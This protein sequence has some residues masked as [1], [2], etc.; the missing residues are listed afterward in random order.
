MAR[1]PQRDQFACRHMPGKAFRPV[2]EGDG[3]RLDAGK[4]HPVLV[5]PDTPRVLYEKQ[6]SALKVLASGTGPGNVGI[7]SGCSRGGRRATSG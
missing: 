2:A 4:R 7:R 5:K 6:V 3:D 1:A